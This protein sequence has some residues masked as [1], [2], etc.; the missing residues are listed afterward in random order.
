MQNRISALLFWILLP[1]N[2]KA[3][4]NKVIYSTK[5][6]R[7]ESPATKQKEY[8]AG[9]SVNIPIKNARASQK[10]AAKIEGPI[11]FMA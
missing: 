9:T 7:T 11:S 8:K 4:I 1:S 6:Q 5:S 10:A 3:A 2:V